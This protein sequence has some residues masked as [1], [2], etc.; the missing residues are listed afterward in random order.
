MKKIFCTLL[1][2][3]LSVPVF[4]AEISAIT[5]QEE[6]PV[7][8]EGERLLFDV[9]P[10]ISEGRILAPVRG[11]AEAL[12]AE[13][14]WNDESKTVKILSGDKEISFC[15]GEKTVVMD[16]EEKEIDVSARIIAG[17][18]FVPMR[19]LAEALELEV[20]WD[21]EAKT[22]TLSL[23]KPFK[24]D[25]IIPGTYY[26][27]SEV[28]EGC[29]I[30]CK[31]MVLS[32][33]FG[34]EYTFEEVLE[35]NG[36]GVYCNWGEEFCDGVSWQIIMD[37]ELPL[38]EESEDWTASEYTACEKLYMIAE[39]IKDS[40]G[41]IAQFAK[42]G[43]THG[44]VITGFTAEGELIV[45]DPD[46]KS[47]SPQNTLIKDSALAKM[48]DLCTADELLPYLTSMRMIAN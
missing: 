4:A 32:N 8:L 23:K 2:L 25:Y 33:H 21:D 7:Y 12:E 20:L 5:R 16:G 35:K 42:D 39:N 38:K 18:T 14:L 28:F 26:V 13:V 40:S 47:E 41:I 46:T 37:N 19:A 3:I 27:K 45:C 15:I 30:A 6:I 48:F 24:E 22:A 34:R 44:V 1:I 31:T 29:V 43:K 17:R 9:P 11:I 10:V 36:G